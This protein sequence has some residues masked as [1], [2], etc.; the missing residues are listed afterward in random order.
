MIKMERLLP[1]NPPGTRSKVGRSE[2]WNGL[3]L[4]ADN[5]LPFVPQMT[6][7]KVVRARGREPV[8]PRDRVP[9]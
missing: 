2:V 3:V 5:A 1:V 6:Y 9:R 4:K 7:C 8:R